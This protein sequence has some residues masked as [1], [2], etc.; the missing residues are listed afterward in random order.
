MPDDRRHDLHLHTVR[1]DGLYSPMQVADLARRTGLAGI[2]FTDHDTLPDP[3]T[4]ATLA[5]RTGL[6]LLSG[7]E[8]SV[9]LD[10]RGLHLLG[11]G[12]DPCD[13]ALKGL[14]D[15]LQEQRRIRWRAM[16][17]LLEGSGAIG[18]R[19]TY[20][21]PAATLAPGR[22]HL[23][24]RLVERRRAGSV[25]AAFAKF[26]A[27]LPPLPFDR[28]GIGAAVDVL[29]A[30]GGVAVLAH[31]PPGL[32]AAQW[33]ALAAAGIDG[34]EAGHPSAGAAHAAF[35]RERVAEHGWLATA[36][37][38]YHGDNPGRPLGRC[39]VGNDL[40]ARLNDMR[41]AHAYTPPG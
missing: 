6:A 8:L 18:D 15:R 40:V 35:L 12:F 24:R 23:A 17:D 41:T 20:P 36:G 14:C 1:S 13:A 22:L 5:E 32:T 28:P 38:D 10:G 7:V 9:R 21:P 31:P 4:L 19:R 3:D 37:S 11:Y 25:R 2:A 30:A 39:T 26:L 33:R 27:P 29:H 16:L 34:I